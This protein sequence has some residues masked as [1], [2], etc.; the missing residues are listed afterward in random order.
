MQDDEIIPFLHELRDTTFFTRDL[1][2]YDHKLCHPRYCL[3]C[4]SVRKDE[5]AIFVP[6]GTPNSIQKPNGWVQLFVSLTQG[7]RLHDA[8]SP[9]R[10]TSIG[11]LLVHVGKHSPPEHCCKQ[12]GSAGRFEFLNLAGGFPAKR[13]LLVTAI[14]HCQKTSHQFGPRNTRKDMK[15]TKGFRGLRFL[16]ALHGASPDGKLRLD[17]LAFCAGISLV[18]Y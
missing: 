17:F 1:G 3:V 6:C 18:R 9:K 11:E 15:G 12:R 5:V 7:F 8:T 10:H 13:T 4:L 14:S 2:F 16:H